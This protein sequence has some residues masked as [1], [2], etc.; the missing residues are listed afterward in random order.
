MPDKFGQRKTPP[1][2]ARGF[3]VLQGRKYTKQWDGYYR[4]WERGPWR[5]HYLHIDVYAAEYGPVPDGWEVHHIDYN[6]DNNAPENFEAWC[7]DRH[8]AESKREQIARHVQK[9]VD[10]LLKLPGVEC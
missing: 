10:Y 4:C 8:G 2:I 9:R 6:L 5:R 3:Q 1:P 7:K